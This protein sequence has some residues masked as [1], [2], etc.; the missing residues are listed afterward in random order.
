MYCRWLY[1]K[2]GVFYRLPT[3]AEWEYAC[4]AGTTT[5]Y[6]FGDDSSQLKNYAW[7]AGNS[8]NKF[9]KAGQKLPNAWGL[10]D[11]LGNVSEWTL[12]HYDEKAL[13][14]LKDKIVDPFPAFVAARYPK[15]LKG[16]GYND[17]LVLRSASRIKSDP[18]WN[19][20][21]PQVPKSKWWLTEAPS[22]GFRI[23]RPLKQP[24]AEE[25]NA[26]FKQYLGQ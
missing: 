17:A 13:D 14:K 10:F 16:G 3:E 12:D 7:Y 24:S 15:V 1:S 11:M 18:A 8:N 6:Y 4:R 2:T 26:F 19:R 20:R 22:V 25:A 9:E 5:T 23:I 21:D